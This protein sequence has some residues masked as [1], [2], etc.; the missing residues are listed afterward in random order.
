MGFDLGRMFTVPSRP[1]W[2]QKTGIGLG[3]GAATAGLVAITAGSAAPLAPTILAGAAVGGFQGSNSNKGAGTVAQQSAIGGGLT[4]G[5]VAVGAEAVKAGEAARIKA[6]QAVTTGN[7]LVLPQA[8]VTSDFVTGLSA[9]AKKAGTF[10]VTAPQKAAQ[11]IVGSPSGA[12]ARKAIGKGFA[13]LF[14]AAL[15]GWGSKK[16]NDSAQPGGGPGGAPAA[17]GS[18]PGAILGAASNT[19]QGA[20]DGGMPL[21]LVLLIAA[22]ILAA[23]VYLSKK[24]ARA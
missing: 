20:S 8:S 22:A 17:A 12:E 16:I 19:P 21:P 13:D 14:S 18:G 2:L 1:S 9:W 7:K 5:L 4:A 6:A 11:E 24:V 10:L 23:A 3:A 15:L